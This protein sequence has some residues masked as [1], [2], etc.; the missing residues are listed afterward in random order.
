MIVKVRHRTKG[1]ILFDNAEEVQFESAPR[2]VS[3]EQ[4]KFMIGEDDPDV[5]SQMLIEHA[6]LDA[7]ASL[8]V[9]FIRF[10]R[11]GTA[12]ALAINT[13]AYLLN[14]SGKTVESIRVEPKYDR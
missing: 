2:R 1:W 3:P 5:N 11:N 14:D 8:E 6:E 13:H 4:V 7:V 12:Y 10:L 9:A